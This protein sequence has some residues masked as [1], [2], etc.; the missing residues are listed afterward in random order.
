[1]WIGF[2]LMGA[3]LVLWAWLTDFTIIYGAS[4]VIFYLA[5]AAFLVGLI[6]HKRSP[7]MATFGFSFAL[8]MLMSVV[9]RPHSYLGAAAGFP[10]LD[11]QFAAFD[12][13]IGF[14]WVAHVAWV[15]D[16]PWVHKIL[17]GAYSSLIMQLVF[18]FFVLYMTTNYERLRE[19]L[20]VFFGMGIVTTLIATFTPAAGAFYHYQ[21]DAALIDNLTPQTGR[22]FQEHFLALHSGTMTSVIITKSVGLIAFPSFHTQAAVLYAW[23]MRRTKI[24]WPFLILNTLM[25]FSTLT[26]GGHYVIDL[27]AGMAV[28]FAVIFAYGLWT[29]RYRLSRVS[30]RVP[31]IADKTGFIRRFPAWEALK[32]MRQRRQMKKADA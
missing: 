13:L 31:N 2:V 12:H 16:H 14:D 9:L 11:D 29:G 7:G 26:F 32:E 4:Y 23:S 19:F 10:L 15:N 25:I 28:T 6:Y 20:M 27:I 17:A 21:P 18:I 1:M 22:Y 30:L 3:A 24:F 5:A 8:F